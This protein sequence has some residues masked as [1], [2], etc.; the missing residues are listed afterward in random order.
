MSDRGIGL[1]CPSCPPG[2][3]LDAGTGPLSASV[4]RSCDGALVAPRFA[5]AL[6]PALAAA[7]PW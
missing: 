3:P 4:C 1:D 2:T 5:E 6:R 7:S